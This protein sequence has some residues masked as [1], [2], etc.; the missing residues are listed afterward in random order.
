MTTIN[1][2]NHK[3]PFA[4]YE[5]LVRTF[6]PAGERW[7]MRELNYIDFKKDRDASLFLLHWAE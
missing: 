1:L 7:T 5:W 3:I 4:A 6:G 2:S